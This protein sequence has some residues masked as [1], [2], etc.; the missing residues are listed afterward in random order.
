MFRCRVKVSDRTT[1][2]VRNASAESLLPTL[3]PIWQRFQ[4]LGFSPSSKHI[5]NPKWN[6]FG[7]G[8]GYGSRVCS[9]SDRE[10]EGEIELWNEHDQAVDGRSSALCSLYAALLYREVL[11]GVK[12]ERAKAQLLRC[13]GSKLEEARQLDPGSRLVEALNEHRELFDPE[14]AVAEARWVDWIR[15]TGCVEDGLQH[16][17]QGVRRWWNHAGEGQKGRRLVIV[18][19]ASSLHLLGEWELDAFQSALIVEPDAEV[20]QEVLR[21]LVKLFGKRVFTRISICFQDS[22]EIEL[23]KLFFETIVVLPDAGTALHYGLDKIE[24]FVESLHATGIVLVSIDAQEEPHVVDALQP[25]RA[26]ALLDEF[27]QRLRRSPEHASSLCSLFVRRL[28]DAD[29]DSE[30]SVAKCRKRFAPRLAELEFKPL[31]RTAYFVM[32]GR[33]GKESS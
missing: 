29:L 4:E 6:K 2:E 16:V 18:G 8:S 1:L 12:D 10:L 33:T 30:A 31:K 7:S 23:K 24:T 3:Q 22:L 17:R 20:M 26:C 13:M 32:L 19:A 9:D 5:A 14:Q 11:R 27:E 28:Y 25:E 15:A 21:Q